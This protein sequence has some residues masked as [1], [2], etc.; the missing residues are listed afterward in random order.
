[1]RAHDQGGGPGRIGSWRP[2]RQGRGW[3]RA[4]G[5]GAAILTA[6]VGLVALGAGCAW[7]YARS[8][9]GQARLA[10]LVTRALHETQ[11]GFRL[12]RVGPSGRGGGELVVDD[13]DVYDRQ[14]IRAIHVDR[15]VVRPRW[16]ALFSRRL[17][18]DSVRVEGLAIDARMVPA[19]TTPGGG[20]TPVEP[21]PYLNLVRLGTSSPALSGGQIPAR[22][23]SSSLRSW[24]VGRIEIV[25]GAA[26]YRDLDAAIPTAATFALVASAAG[27]GANVGL[28]IDDFHGRITGVPGRGPV[29][30]GLAG[31]VRSM[32]GTV[33]AHVT[34]LAVGGLLPDGQAVAARATLHLAG[35]VPD[36][37]SRS[38]GRVANL[39]GTIDV[40][41]A[42]HLSWTGAVT[43]AEVGLGDFRVAARVYDLPLAAI[44]PSTSGQVSGQVSVSGAGIPL[45]PGS[46]AAVTVE[47]SP[48]QVRSVQLGDV[49]VRVTAI[50]EHWSLTRLSAHVEG[51][52]VRGSGEGVGATGKGHLEIDVARSRPRRRGADLPL[53]RVTGRGHLAADVES[54]WPGRV[55]VHLAGHVERL[56][57]DGAARIGRARLDADAA[58]THARATW[59]MTSRGRVHIAGVATAAVLA[60]EATVSWRARSG[61]AK[62][63]A[64]PLARLLTPAGMLTLEAR[65]VRQ[66]SPG[67]VSVSALAVDAHGDGRRLT[68][69]A[70]AVGPRGQGTV[71]AEVSRRAREV[72]MAF[73]RAEVAFRI[74]PGAKDAVQRVG[75]TGPAVIT[76]RPGEDEVSLS[77]F[78][79]RGDGPLGRGE[80]VADGT[81]AW[82]GSARP[83]GH[84][85][86]AVGLRGVS[87]Q[88]LPVIDADMVAA[89]ADGRATG[90]LH[91]RTGAGGGIPREPARKSAELRASLDAPVSLTSRGLVIAPTGALSGSVESLDVDLAGL[92]PLQRALARWGLTG[93]RFNVRAS[94]AGDVADPRGTID[95]DVRGLEYRDVTGDGRDAVVHRVPGIGFTL[96]VAT[97]AHQIRISNRL[98]LYG[99]GFA[100]MD[101]SV[102]LGLAE[103]MRGA[104]VRHAPLSARLDLPRFQIAAFRS[105]SDELRD[106]TGWLSAHG[107]LAGTLAAPEGAVD[108]RLDDAHIDQVALGP[109]VAHADTDGRRARGTLQVRT[110]AAGTLAVTASLLKP[111][112]VAAGA[113]DLDLRLDARG[114]DPGF[115]RPFL[116]D[117][118]ELGGV[119]DA[120]VT[121]KGRWPRPVIDGRLYF[122]RGRVGVTGQP[123]FHDIGV[124][125]ALSPGRVDIGTLQVHSG[126]GVLTGQGRVTLEGTQVVSGDLTAR[127]QRFL[128]AAAG[129]SGS[130]LDGDLQ[131]HVGREGPSHLAGTATVPSAT[132]WLPGLSFGARKVQRI[133]PHEDV[134]FVDGASRAAAE[135]DAASTATAPATTLTLRGQARTIYVRAKDVDLE[136][137]SRLILQ[138]SSTGE[139]SLVGVI[140]FRRGRIA[141]GSQRFELDD[142]RI[143]FDGPVTPRLDLR[144]AHT[145]PEATVTVE[146]RGT[147]ARPELR[148]RSDPPIYDQAQIVSLV[149]T[150]HLSGAPGGPSPDPT[151]VIA[152]AV[153]GQLADKLAP[154]LGLDV[155]KVERA[156]ATP[157]QQSAGLLAQRVEIGKYVT[158]R[159]Y[160]S[161][162][163]VFG[164]NETQNTNEAQA[165]YRLTAD[166]MAQTVFGD[167]GVG[168]V[169]AFWT[170]RY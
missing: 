83:R 164:A 85:R 95:V 153:L 88:G 89:L 130:R 75:L 159:I 12:G 140:R 94:V 45:Q 115:A 61:S 65:D 112:G 114:I 29:S 144:L 152:S 37:P 13:L 123:T 121:A 4:L 15:V 50:G 56:D 165:E 109:V 96:A 17:E 3:R 23:S 92:P 90:K 62:G 141:I 22:S 16:R 14:G 71:D 105:A 137:E 100:T 25:G 30:V 157:E 63:S 139:P 2:A 104:D 72:A 53:S 82:P 87:T 66:P 21:G 156:A 103:L 57:V 145:F 86:V 132:V 161:Y 126:D 18:L 167:A 31:D 110:G 117:V 19:E 48:S 149:L 160:V 73:S 67:G 91:V 41:A 11:P 34:K 36:T 119:I 33:D 134:R 99:G 24:R 84:G 58:V 146:L 158:E 26:T 40:G 59:S 128:I 43:L 64:S 138:T 70:R 93:G 118:R 35:A 168:G 39:D 69:S 136:L 154:Q 80:V 55:A 44:E 74:G 6:V 111:T 27:Q 81:F 125:I 162:A 107:Q 151:A 106:T 127:A 28:E 78:H 76:L 148:F 131:V 129:V 20:G 52:S 46:H 163:H 155:L 166:W 49:L 8:D 169:D 170:R 143:V 122:Y 5:M 113:P 147:A 77:G 54:D 10:R 124:A 97:S 1:M 32:A 60:D 42:G 79:V 51:V 98:A 102:G 142:S 135:R 38:P 108:L 150:G 7:M 47:L 133:K 116:T 9:H 101:A 120:Q 68:V